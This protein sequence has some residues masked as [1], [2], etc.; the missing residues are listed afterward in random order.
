MV[1]GAVAESK[2][3]IWICTSRSLKARVTRAERLRSRSTAWR[4][5]RASSALAA[6]V[7]QGTTVADIAEETGIGQL[8]HSSV[9]GAERNS[10]VAHFES[11]T[12]IEAYTHRIGVPATVLR[13]VFF[14]TN[15]LFL[16]NIS[17]SGERVLSMPLDPATPVQMVS[18]NNIGL[19]AATA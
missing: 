8:V 19:F 11:K 3:R 4:S 7:C 14:M 5:S 12:A 13:P 2:S 18:A 1:R 6:E 10:G 16:A 17:D 15:L 9:G